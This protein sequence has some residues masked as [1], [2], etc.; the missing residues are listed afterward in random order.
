MSQTSIVVQTVACLV[1][2]QIT[3]TGSVGTTNDEAAALTQELLAV[4]MTNHYER[5]M[6]PMFGANVQ[7]R[8]FDNVDTLERSA[9][10]DDIATELRAISPLLQ[11]GDV[12]F[13]D[14]ANEPS[15]VVLSVNYSINSS[16]AK[17]LV[18][19]PLNGIVTTD[20]LI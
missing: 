13:T 5:V 16:N 8:L 11:I 14:D 17:L 9:A 6:L 3:P 18:R 19:I 15:S 10:A 1:P 7:G 4:L 20:T 12:S 2:F